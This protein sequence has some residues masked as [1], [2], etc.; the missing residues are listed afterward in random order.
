MDTPE[1][2]RQHQVGRGSEDW[3]NIPDEFATGKRVE[4]LIRVADGRMAGSMITSRDVG[5]QACVCCSRPAAARRTLSAS[6]NNGFQAAHAF[7]IGELS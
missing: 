3:L 5:A 1:R 6:Y 7:G 2:Q 4:L